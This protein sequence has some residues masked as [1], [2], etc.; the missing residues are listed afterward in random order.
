MSG[1]FGTLSKIVGRFRNLRGATI[2]NFA[3]V[4]IGYVQNSIYFGFFSFRF[5]DIL[6][7]VQHYILNLRESR[8]VLKFY[9]TY[10]NWLEEFHIS[11][12]LEPIADIIESVLDVIVKDAKNVM[13][14]FLPYIVSISEALFGN[15][16]EINKLFEVERCRTILNKIYSKTLWIW[17]YN[18]LSETIKNS[19]HKII[20]GFDDYLTS[21]LTLDYDR[22]NFENILDQSEYVV[23]SDIGLIEI[24]Q[25]IPFEWEALDEM[26][27]FNQVPLYDKL[28]HRFENLIKLER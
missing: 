1:I 24:T 13:K 5:S 27:R 28:K 15:Y 6:D 10:I 3:N 9:V 20:A 14:D 21:L 25:P 4:S 11:D 19:L 23:R 12:I 7:N 2:G 26:P 16:E 17:N 22:N 8:E 18:N